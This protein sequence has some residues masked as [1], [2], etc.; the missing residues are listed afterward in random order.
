MPAILAV[1]C[2]ADDDASPS[3]APA[4]QRVVMAGEVDDSN[5]FVALVREGDDVI[6]YVCDSDRVSRWCESS[7]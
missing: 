7:T 3:G 5:A 1:G 6:A 4:V 2:S